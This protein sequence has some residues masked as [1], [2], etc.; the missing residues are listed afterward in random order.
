MKQTKDIPV[1]EAY[2][3]ILLLADHI[4]RT[5]PGHMCK[6]MVDPE[7]GE[8]TICLYNEEKDECI[9]I[10]IRSEFATTFLK[11]GKE[12]VYEFQN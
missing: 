12:G 3:K 10:N 9:S 6:R 8:E 4:K 2:R 1:D 11:K 5:M 7:N